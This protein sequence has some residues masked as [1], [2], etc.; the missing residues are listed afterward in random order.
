MVEKNK[1]ASVQQSCMGAVIM[2]AGLLLNGGC[3]LYAFDTIKKSSTASVCS[4][5]WL[6][7]KSINSWSCY[8]QPLHP[9]VD[10]WPQTTYRLIY[11]LIVMKKLWIITR[12]DLEYNNNLL[13]ILAEEAWTQIYVK[14]CWNLVMKYKNQLQAVIIKKL[15]Q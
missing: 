6:A 3:N 10:Q 12:F 8:C 13:V 15:L 9:L 1:G 2:R 11:F 4:S 7:P 14:R 5:C